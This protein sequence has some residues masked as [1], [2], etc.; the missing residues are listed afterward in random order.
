MRNLSIAK[1]LLIV[2]A[3]V[4]IPLGGFGVL[5]YYFYSYIGVSM[6]KRDYAYHMEQGKKEMSKTYVGEKVQPDYDAMI[7]HAKKAIAEFQAA[8]DIWEADHYLVDNPYG[9]LED[10]KD[11]LAGITD[12]KNALSAR[13]A[14]K[15]YLVPYEKFNDKLTKAADGIRGSK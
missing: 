6:Q 10:A 14:E 5:M 3:L 15:Q 9:N 1:R 2:L 13:Q 12:A 8:Y 7:G 4:V 11:A